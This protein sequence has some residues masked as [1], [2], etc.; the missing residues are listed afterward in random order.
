M[1]I[2][3]SKPKTQKLILVADKEVNLYAYAEQT[4]Y[5]FMPFCQNAGQN[6]M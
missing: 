4:G 3:W 1:V 6:V 5:A 2:Y